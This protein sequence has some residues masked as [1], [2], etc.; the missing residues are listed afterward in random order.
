[1]TL[2]VSI[3]RPR[4]SR[5]PYRNVAAGTSSSSATSS[6]VTGVGQRQVGL[7]GSAVAGHLA[8]ADQGV[9]VLGERD[10]VALEE[11]RVVAPP[12]HRVI[13]DGDVVLPRNAAL[14][15]VQ[16]EKGVR[17]IVAAEDGQ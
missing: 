17:R 13:A 2:S 12:G 3:V 7:P 9:A 10:G 6:A 1:M 5:T 4:S 16:H 11:F 8:P 14:V 15:E